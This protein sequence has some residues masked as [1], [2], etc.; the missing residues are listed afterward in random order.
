M[1]YNFDEL[2]DL[3][4]EH[5]N[6]HKDVYKLELIGNDKKILEEEICLALFEKLYS[7]FLIN[8][9]SYGKIHLLSRAYDIINYG[10]WIKYLE[11]E[12]ENQLKE[13]K[14]SSN[15]LI[16][17]YIGG[18]NHGIQSSKSDFIK[19][20]IQNV[21]KITETKASKKSFF[22]IAS[23]VLGGIAAGIAIYEF[24]IK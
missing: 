11:I 17:N 1:N 10:G 14:K 8:T 19:P 15:I 6:K 16:E 12:K 18:N 21:N 4:I 20:T 23:W 24:I 9:N 13:N 5:I 22:E 2:I 3:N 7:E